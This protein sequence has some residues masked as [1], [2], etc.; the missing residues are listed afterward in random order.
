MPYSS[1][2]STVHSTAGVARAQYALL[3]ANGV[4]QGPS[5]L[6]SNGQDA[7]FGIYIAVKKSGGSLPPPRTVDVTGD[8]GRFHHR[9]TFQAASIGELDMAFG[10]FNDSAAALF[11]GTKL[12]TSN[13]EWVMSG[14]ETNQRANKNSVAVIINAD[15]Q[16]ANS[17]TDGQPRFINWIYPNVVV[18]PQLAQNEEANGAEWG[19]RGI[20]TSVGQY[21]WGTDFSQAINGFTKAT[22][23]K[24]NSVDPIT[25]H[26]FI[27]DGSKSGFFLNYTPSSD[28]TGYAIKAWNANTGA[29]VTISSVDVGSKKVTLSAIPAA[30]VPIV[31]LY[32]AFDLL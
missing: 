12:D 7:G 28:Q 30:G 6:L 21:P 23:I 3:D 19:W 15:S 22:R 27:G 24:V 1:I 4:P 8:N 16:D 25:M 5:G 32:E 9:Y 26:T 29:A 17:G 20:L 11:T 13:A 31:V 18:Y 2:S 10:A 14:Y